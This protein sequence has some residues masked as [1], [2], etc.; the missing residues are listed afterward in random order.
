MLHT[1]NTSIQKAQKEVAW[2]FRKAALPSI[3]LKTMSSSTNHLSLAKVITINMHRKSGRMSGR[4][5]EDVRLRGKSTITEEGS[6][7]FTHG[8]FCSS[9]RICI[10]LAREETASFLG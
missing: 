10:N 1:S 5:C 8:T 4:E 6:Q 3:H 9:F 7:S 2:V